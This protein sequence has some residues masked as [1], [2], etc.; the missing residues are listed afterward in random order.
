[1]VVAE[2]VLAKLAGV[3]AEVQQNLPSAGVPGFY[4]GLPGNCGG[5]IPVRNGYMPVKKALRPDVQLCMAR[6]MKIAPSCPIRSMLVFHPPSA[7]GD[8]CSA[9]SIRCHRP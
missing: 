2:V 5:I 7:P 3:V 4:V 1:V 8:K 6:S 9:A